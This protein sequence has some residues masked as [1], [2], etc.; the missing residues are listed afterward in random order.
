MKFKMCG[1]NMNRKYYTGKVRSK[2]K[3][4]IFRKKKIISLTQINKFVN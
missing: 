3:I 2:N 4:L 1:E